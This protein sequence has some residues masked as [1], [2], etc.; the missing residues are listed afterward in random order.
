[1]LH[2]STS[3]CRTVRCSTTVETWMS[4]DV[5]VIALVLICDVVMKP[6]ILLQRAALT[7]EP[8]QCPMPGRYDI[9]TGSANCDSYFRS[10]CNG[11]SVI[12]IISTCSS[13]PGQSTCHRKWRSLYRHRRASA[14]DS[15]TFTIE[16]TDWTV[17][18]TDMLI[19]SWKSSQLLVVKLFWRVVSNYKQLTQMTNLLKVI[20]W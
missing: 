19:T 14:I 3:S 15:S 12:D 16:T 5:D 6:L 17:V 7:L 2:V 1:M 20:Q 9:L 4:T 11:S 13:R 18:N 8:S 10:G